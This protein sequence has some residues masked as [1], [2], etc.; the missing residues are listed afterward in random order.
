MLTRDRDPADR[1]AARLTITPGARRRLAAWR[2]RRSALIGGIFADL[3]DEDVAA[4]EAAL[5]AIRR[6]LTR[7]CS[8]FG[9][10]RTPNLG[11]DLASPAHS[12]CGRL[13]H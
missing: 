3:P 7:R 9:N 10:Y 1:R 2:E 5:P 11:L 13:G 8:V 6:V 12:R 4:S